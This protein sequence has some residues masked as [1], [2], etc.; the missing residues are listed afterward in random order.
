MHFK[1]LVV[2]AFTLHIYIYIYIY[3]TISIYLSISIYISALQIGAGQRS[4]TASLWSLTA[5]IY[6]VMVIVTGGFSK[7]FL[8]FFSE[9]AVRRYYSKRVSLEIS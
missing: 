7:K 9:A 1:I 8:Y 6:H 5:H 3:I 4:V 2:F